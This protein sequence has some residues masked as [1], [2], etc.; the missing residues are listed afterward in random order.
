MICI[1][2]SDYISQKVINKGYNFNERFTL[3]SSI[4]MNFETYAATD[5]IF[6]IA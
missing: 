1:L 6:F 5:K 4:L 2:T 3:S